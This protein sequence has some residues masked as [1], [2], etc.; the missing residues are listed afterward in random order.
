M[1]GMTR[2]VIVI[3]AACLICTAIYSQI[4]YTD[5]VFSMYQIHERN[6]QANL[7]STGDIAKYE[8]C[9]EY[10]RKAS[11]EGMSSRLEFFIVASLIPTS[12]F[13]AVLFI[14]YFIFIW[15]RKGFR[16]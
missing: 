11:K 3:V 12:A 14:A 16:K 2:I 8:L 5:T 10:A 7:L 9:T 15:I 13:I 1:A 4:H 6:C